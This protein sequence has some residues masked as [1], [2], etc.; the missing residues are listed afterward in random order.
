MISILFV[1]LFS[2]LVDQLLVIVLDQGNFKSADFSF[3]STS[4]FSRSPRR[5]NRRRNR[6][7][8]T[9]RNSKND[10]ERLDPPA[11]KVLGV[12]G[13]SPSTDEAALRQIF[14]PFGRISSIHVVYDRGVNYSVF[15]LGNKSNESFFCLFQ[16]GRSRGFGFI[17]FE[18]I[19]DAKEVITIDRIL[20]DDLIYSFYF[21][22][23]KETQGMKIDGG[24]V[25]V[26]FSLTEKPHDPT[27]GVYMGT[28]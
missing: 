26:A 25:R 6:S 11:S 23:R 9:D 2:S 14:S 22:A 20:V 19:E 7:R 24:T 27:P 4:L 13:L 18:R 15:F 10:L 28:P 17:Y 16:T 12:F 8:S 21:Q 5:D 1:S 3:Q